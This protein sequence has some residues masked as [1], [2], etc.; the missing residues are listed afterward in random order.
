MRR[1][2]Q[3]I[4]ETKNSETT[5]LGDIYGSLWEIE[6]GE[7]LSTYGLA[8]EDFDQ[9]LPIHTL[10]VDQLKALRAYGSEDTVVEM[11]RN[12]APEQI[13]IV[14]HYVEN[15][16]DRNEKP[17]VTEND[18]ALDGYH[19]IIAAIKVGEPLR[20]VNTADLPDPD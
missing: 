9:P 15:P 7:I 10:S 4:T 17:I 3:F 18:A 11:F 13:E 8:E 14:K 20:S 19:R 2:L 5:T 1:F 16:A 12:A 6:E